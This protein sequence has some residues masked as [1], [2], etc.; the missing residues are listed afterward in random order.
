[1]LSK[2]QFAT[3]MPVRQMERAIKFYTKAL[4]AKLQ[5]RAEGDMK[6]MWASIKIGR[7][8]FWL[9]K[10]SGR[11]EKKPDLAFSTFVVK[12][13]RSEVKGLQKQGVK[14]E[15]PEKNAGWTTK[16]EGPISYD[17]VGAT[18][19]FKDTE[20]NLLMLYQGS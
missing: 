9:I 19:F 16:V 2:A 8:V 15:P 20:G 18:A 17:P 1:M 10:P 7:E 11:Q 3:L 13:I 4:G 5:M 6:D 14:F 12:D